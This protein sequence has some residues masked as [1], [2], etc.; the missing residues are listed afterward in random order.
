MIPLRDNAH[1]H[2]ANLMKATLATTGWEIMNL[3]PCSHDFH[4]VGPIKVHLEGQKF[5]SDD[6]LKCVVLNRFCSQDKI[7]HSTEI[8]NLPGQWTEMC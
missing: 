4:V 3:L 6:E 5:Q 8:S 2:T 7:F 1:P